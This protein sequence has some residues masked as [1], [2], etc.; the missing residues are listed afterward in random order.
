MPVAPTTSKD[1]GATFATI[2]NSLRNYL[3][4]QVDDPSIAE[5]LLQDVFVKALVTINANRTPANLTGWL[6][7]VARTTVV[8]YY[9]SKRLDV[10]ELDEDLPDTQQI[11]DELLHR[12]LAN[13]LRPLTL[14]L[15]AIYRDTLLATDFGG[16]TM[17]SLAKEQGLSR[18]AIK[19]RASRA[20]VMLKEKLLECC[21]V[22]QAG[23][24]VT[25]YR[26]RSSST[27]KVEC[28]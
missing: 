7:A 10:T 12:E 2:Q 16:Q 15:P 8:D 24:I 23:G 18:S 14:Q 28:A 21:H 20:R 26:P 27:C 25:D 13:C 22:E 17:S 1:I 11:N 5:D 9:R 6:Y 3:R 4:R 19:S